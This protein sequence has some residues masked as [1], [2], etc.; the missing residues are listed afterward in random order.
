[1]RSVVAEW[2]RQGGTREPVIALSDLEA[3]RLGSTASSGGS[4]S[5]GDDELYLKARD[6]VVR[7]QTGSTSMLQ[8]SL[9]V[10]FARAGRL[11]DM[12]EEEGVVGPSDGSKTREVLWSPE[13]LDAELQ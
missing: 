4:S 2:Q 3:P 7:N 9:R 12:L 1:V 6:L 5:G 11:M 13:Q 8:R 10:G